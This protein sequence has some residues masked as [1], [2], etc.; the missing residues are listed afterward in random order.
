MRHNAGHSNSE[1]FPY[2]KRYFKETKPTIIIS[3]S[4]VDISIVGL[5]LF[6]YQNFSKKESKLWIISVNLTLTNS[7]V[8]K[9]HC[10]KG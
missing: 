6:Y 8:L 7:M 2:K 3:V 1:S 10:E 5:Y 9:Q 4:K